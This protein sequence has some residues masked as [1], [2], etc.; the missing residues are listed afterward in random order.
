MPHI[1]DLVV[2]RVA[3]LIAPLSPASFTLVEKRAEDEDEVIASESLPACLIWSPGESVETAGKGRPVP[4]L[5][6]VGCMVVVVLESS[7]DIRK[8]LDA[9]GVLVESALLGSYENKH[10]GRLAVRSRLIATETD[11]KRSGEKPVAKLR[12]QL[13]YSVRSWEGQPDVYVQAP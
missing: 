5:R 4:V 11:F 12:M 2:D 8:E 3:A 9:L 1:R 7:G 10:L 6:H 13:E